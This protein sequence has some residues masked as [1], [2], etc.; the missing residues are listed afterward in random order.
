MTSK[1]HYFALGAGLGL[2]FVAGQIATN[3]LGGTLAATPARAD[4]HDPA[5]SFG[6]LDPSLDGSLLAQGRG[7]TNP[8]PTRPQPGQADPNAAPPTV[9]V[10]DGGQTASYGGDFL[11]VTGS[12]GVGTSV[13]YLVDTKSR[14]LAVYEARGGSTEGRRIVLVGARKIDLDLQLEKYND[15]SEYDY[16]DLRRL[17]DSRGSGNQDISTGLEPGKNR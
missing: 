10:E 15:R 16:R 12:Y 17:F 3:L 2:A 13:L 11:A 9:V 1:A 4:A 7:P 5:P 14:Q 8:G 6:A